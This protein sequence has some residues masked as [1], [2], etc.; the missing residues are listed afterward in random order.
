[1]ES[2][3]PTVPIF[4]HAGRTGGDTFNHLLNTVY[5]R[6]RVLHFETYHSAWRTLRDL[7]DDYL[8]V[9]QCIHGHGAPYGI[10]DSLLRDTTYLT[11]CRDPVNR[12]ISQ[13]YIYYHDAAR[14]KHKQIHEN[15]MSLDDYA[16]LSANEMSCYCVGC[17]SYQNEK[18]EIGHLPKIIEI[19]ESQFSFVG[20]TERYNESIFLAH[21]LLGWDEWYFWEKRLE[22]KKRPPLEQISEETRA[23]IESHNVVDRALYNYACDRLERSFGKLSTAE[24]AQFEEYKESQEVYTYLFN[25]G[26]ESLDTEL[27]RVTLQKKGMHIAV[28]IANPQYRVVMD[29]YFQMLNQNFGRRLEVEF[30]ECYNDKELGEILLKIKSPD[31]AIGIMPP[32]KDWVLKKAWKDIRDSDER[33]AFALAH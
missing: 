9:L 18:P 19:M 11:I 20:V 6:S 15:S 16:R 26:I 30:Y 7:P 29:N 32:G 25:A 17:P 2:L 21:K 22:N 27:F 5:N 10:G 23:L 4:T 8:N 33:L 14:G 1:M 3:S 28:I 13:Y 12:V 31:Y 24:H